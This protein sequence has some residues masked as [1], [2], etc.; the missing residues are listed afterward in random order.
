MT[1][2]QLIQE[3]KEARKISPLGGDTVVY[4]CLLDLEYIPVEYT[5]LDIDQSGAVFLIED[6]SLPRR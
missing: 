4:I 6:A 2:D 5:D 1:L 3:A